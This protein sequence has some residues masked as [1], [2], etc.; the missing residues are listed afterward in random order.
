MTKHCFINVKIE[1]EI[2]MPPDK[3]YRKVLNTHMSCL[4]PGDIIYVGDGQIA[5][6]VLSIDHTI[7]KDIICQEIDAGILLRSVF[8]DDN[9]IHSELQING[10]QMVSS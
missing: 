5:L 2:R 1:D 9:E 7:T 6:E 3:E 8:S 10:F 4:I